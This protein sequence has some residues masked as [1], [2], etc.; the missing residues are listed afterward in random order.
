ML[1]SMVAAVDATIAAAV[2]SEEE[3]KAVRSGV[4]FQFLDEMHRSGQGLCVLRIE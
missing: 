2:K 3:E 4:F 1:I